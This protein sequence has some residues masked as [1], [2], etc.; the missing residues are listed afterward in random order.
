[1]QVSIDLLSLIIGLIFGGGLTW[2]FYLPTKKE[3]QEEKSLTIMEDMLLLEKG[4]GVAFDLLRWFKRPNKKKLEEKLG[5][6]KSNTYEK[7]FN[8]FLSNKLI[9]KAP[10]KDQESYC[11]TKEGQKICKLLDELSEEIGYSEPSPRAS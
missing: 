2:L 11:L 4:L 5:N 9:E 3:D 10:D 1:M 8:Y 7:V 6:Q